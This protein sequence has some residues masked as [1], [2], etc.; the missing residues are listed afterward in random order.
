M[1]KIFRRNISGTCVKFAAKKTTKEKVSSSILQELQAKF[2]EPEPSFADLLAKH[3]TSST[4]DNLEPAQSTFNTK[5]KTVLEHYQEIKSRFPNYFVLYQVGEFYEIYGDDVEEASSIMDI[6]TCK[7]T[8]RRPTAMT[9]IPLK[10]S[11]NYIEKII[12]AGKSVV[13][14]DQIVERQMNGV[15]KFSRRISRIITPGT[16]TEDNLL[17]RGQYNF[18]LS[19]SLS[20]QEAIGLAWI[21]ISTGF[22][23][24]KCTDLE[25]FET[26]LVKIDPKEILLSSSAMNIKEIKRPIEAS[27]IPTTEISPSEFCQENGKKKLLELYEKSL[28]KDQIGGLNISEFSLLEMKAVSA[29]LNYLSRT[30][31]ESNAIIDFPI[32]NNPSLSMSIDANTF[33]SLEIAK[34][35]RTNSVKN[36]LL[37]VID[38][39]ITAVG[40]RLLARKLRK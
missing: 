12:K 14:C 39:T 9:G 8:K 22:F 2:D 25:N 1:F 36:S 19:I 38:R 4:S 34:N 21:D 7:S 20:S 35:I 33:R 30:E 5:S 31:T 3:V 15:D 11:D 27:F 32:R 23:S 29:L 24:T 17:D 13:V 28:N 16:L 26:D 10:S 6:A 37:G 40:A 18:L